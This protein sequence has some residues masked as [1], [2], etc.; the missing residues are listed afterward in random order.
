[1]VKHSHCN[2]RIYYISNCTERME[3][4]FIATIKMVEINLRFC[5]FPGIDPSI[6]FS[7]IMGN[8]RGMLVFIHLIKNTIL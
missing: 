4:E 5:H 2:L 1:M 7:I 3:L 8:Y 6:L